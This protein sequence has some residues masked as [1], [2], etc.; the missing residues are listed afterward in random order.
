MPEVWQVL[1]KC[2]FLTPPASFP[3]KKYLF[4]I[5]HYCECN[6]S[7]ITKNNYPVIGISSLYLETYFTAF[8]ICIYREGREGDR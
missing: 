8:D 3:S 4:I 5:I 6:I 1:K 7:S 2:F